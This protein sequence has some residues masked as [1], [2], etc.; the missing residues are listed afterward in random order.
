MNKAEDGIE[1]LMRFGWYRDRNSDWYF[2]NTE[3]NG[4]FGKALVGWNWIDGYCYF[5]DSNG[6][7]L[8]SQSTPDG[9][10]VNEDGRWTEN[11]TVQYIPGKGYRAKSEE[12][13]AKFT[14]TGNLSRKYSSSG[15][16]DSRGLGRSGETGRTS[17]RDLTSVNKE[18]Q[19]NNDFEHNKTES[20]K[21]ELSGSKQA[22]ASE[23][24]KGNSLKL[25]KAT[26]SEPEKASSSESK[27]KDDYC[28]IIFDFNYEGA[29][30]PIIQQVKIGEQA[31]YPQ[32]PSREGYIG[33]AWY[34]DAYAKDLWKFYDVERCSVKEDMILYAHWADIKTD[35]DEDKI[36]DDL[37]KLIGT[38]PLSEDS[39]GD[40]LT[41]YE[42]LYMFYR[43]NPLI[44]D[45]DDNGIIDSD[46][47]ADEDGLSNL[48]ELNGETD[49]MLRDTDEDGLNDYDEIE[50]Y[51]TES[52]EKD[53]DGDGAS[54]GKEVK[55][56]TDPLVP[57]ARFR[58]VEY[59]ESKSGYKVGVDVLLNGNQVDTLK[60]EEVEDKLLFPANM[61]GYI[62]SAFEFTVDGEIDTATISFEF[63]EELL[64]I[65]EFDPVI[66]YFNEEEQWM[67]EL[68][69]TITGNVA[70]ATTTH[71]SKYILADR[72]A[73]KDIFKYQ[74]D[75]HYT[76]SEYNDIEVVLVLDET[77]NMYENDI[78]EERYRILKKL[79]NSMPARAKIGIVK[80]NQSAEVSSGGLTADKETIMQIIEGGYE[81]GSSYSDLFAVED[82]AFSMFST[83]ENTLRIVVILTDVQ[84]NDYMLAVHA[85][86]KALD[87]KAELD[88]IGFGKNG[89]VRYQF[90]LEQMA[91]STGGQY[92]Y[93][94]NINEL[95]NTINNIEYRINVTEDSDKDGLPD[96]YE[97]NGIRL[98]NNRLVKSNKNSKDS[99]RDTLEDSRE[100]SLAR[101]TLQDGREI[102]YGVM[103][104]DPMY[105]D[106]DEDTYKDPDDP[107]PRKSDVKIVALT[108]ADKF[109][110][111]Y[112]GSDHYYGGDQGW[113][114]DTLN[115]MGLTELGEYARGGGCGPVAAANIMA[116]MHDHI[117]GCEALYEYD[118][119]EKDNFIKH[120]IQVIAHVTPLALPIVENKVIPIS[121][122]TGFPSLSFEIT[123]LYPLG[124][125]TTWDM[126]AGVKSFAKSRG[127]SLKGISK[128]RFS[129]KEDL[130]QHI[131]GG[132]EKDSP[133]AILNIWNTSMKGYVYNSDG[134]KKFK[135]EQKF[136]PHWMVITEMK[137]DDIRGTVE[138][139]VA[140]WGAYAT[141]DLDDFIEKEGL[142]NDVLYFEVGD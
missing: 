16:G 133:V 63:D 84:E 64:S 81:G 92:Y 95:S 70:S 44:R 15:S 56:G 138:L 125:P 72:K 55:I 33:I 120:M 98:F 22:T 7:M 59:I 23:A 21:T 116:Y 76:Y 50:V 67:E 134:T 130:W 8:S 83:Q 27:K 115:S 20:N 97:E 68:D 111:V 26:S 110:D 61:P 136:S 13:Y 82:D 89:N 53:T 40:E 24:E 36:A 114:Y 6:K 49:P 80:V 11:G 128:S 60:I 141:I 34:E 131:K 66:Y 28:T 129:G 75:Y 77:G 113:Y 79:V 18:T 142:L 35:T 137:K 118:D 3:H 10:M 105:I 109:V 86:Q 100:I 4:S 47:D 102:V 45:S 135:A 37:E 39:D 108:D 1:G 25:E 91:R 139:K 43:Y 123:G 104:S 14:S 2:L 71:F 52:L 99:D 31:K 65:P 54:D 90:V 30:D 29:P 9:Y 93:S 117:E 58:I 48:Y 5:F 96:Y 42:E 101:K 57:E 122:N 140:T 121:E 94:A 62:D 74:S 127:V 85:V 132:L 38:E 78:H 88:M 124:I 73:R 112:S 119:Y 107:R 32:L 51:K 41:D 69:T 106:T 87:S 17:W 46:E 19:N 126:Q 12:A 103:K